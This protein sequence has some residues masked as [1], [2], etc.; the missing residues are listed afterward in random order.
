MWTWKRGRSEPIAGRRGTLSGQ[1][2]SPL[3]T[4]AMERGRSPAA[5]TTRFGDVR[6]VRRR[7]LRRYEEVLESRT[8]PEPHV[9]NILI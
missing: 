7:N 8:G 9:F 4:G 3:A 1:A 6:N 5:E 2:Q